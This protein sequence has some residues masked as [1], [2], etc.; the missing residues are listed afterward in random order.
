MRQPSKNC[1]LRKLLS[2]WRGHDRAFRNL[3]GA[4]CILGA[5]RFKRL[6]LVCHASALL[7]ELLNCL[8]RCTW[9]CLLLYS[10]SL[11]LLERRTNNAFLDEYVYAPHAWEDALFINYL[12][13][14]DVAIEIIEAEEIVCTVVVCLGWVQASVFVPIY[15]YLA[16]RDFA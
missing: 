4:V 15:Y 14:H 13:N 11:T 8:S 16:V 1:N 3:S 10:T 6:E 12:R 5:A 9:S 7:L 2:V